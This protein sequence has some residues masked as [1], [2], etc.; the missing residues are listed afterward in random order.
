MADPGADAHDS[1]ARTV[2][3]VMGHA[4][5]V[6]ASY[7]ATTL[8]GIRPRSL[9]ATP[10]SFAHPRIPPLAGRLAEV[11]AGRRRHPAPALRARP[12]LGATRCRRALAFF[13]LRSISYPA[14]PN[15]DRTRLNR[16]AALQ[17]VFELDRDP[18]RHGRPPSPRLATRTVQDQAESSHNRNASCAARLD[19]RNHSSA[20]S[21][22]CGPA[23]G[24]RTGSR[25]AISRADG[26]QV[27]GS[28][29]HSQRGS[30]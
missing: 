17:I 7:R 1:T 23:P 12:R 5:R 20:E 22:G 3:S 24:T 10:C 6:A 18:L 26:A 16:R 21:P 13:A 9:T 15:P 28:S 11:R 27:S 30:E 29:L 25:E 14:P 2:G 8:A 4:P 19:S